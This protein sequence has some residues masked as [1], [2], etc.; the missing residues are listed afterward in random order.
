MS[1]YNFQYLLDV[2]NAKSYESNKIINKVDEAVS[3]YKTPLVFHLVP[4]LYSITIASGL[5]V[6]IYNLY[7]RV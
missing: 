6:F 5:G 7:N 1:E 3:N 4:I 2:R